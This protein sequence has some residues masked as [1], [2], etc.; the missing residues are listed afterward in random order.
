MA[1]SE[2]FDPYRELG[3]SPEAAAEPELVRAAFKAL[4]KK[5][6]PD[7]YPDPAGKA[8]AEEKMRK[9]NEAQQ[10]ILS[11]EYRP[12]VATAESL[13]VVTPPSPPPSAPRPRPV[14]PPRR[15]PLTPLVVAA[16]VLLACLALPQMLGRD[17]LKEAAA[18]EQKGRL[19]QALEEAD[20]AV[21]DDPRD[22]QA[23]LVR[24]RIWQ[25]M[26]EP[27]RAQRDLANAR[28]L[29]SE[30]ELE[31]ARSAL[32]PMASPSPSASPSPRR[33]KSAWP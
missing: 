15:V 28:G 13:T 6:H 20:Q 24:A 12:T 18:L 14:S 9:L 30:G 7:G 27:E 1:G 23:Y 10:L 22:G 33:P 16:A 2:P 4:A 5:Y 29:V 26:G 21:I 3:L 32:L 11:G 8:R 25:K 19:P 31:E 17:H